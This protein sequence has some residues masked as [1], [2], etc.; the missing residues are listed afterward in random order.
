MAFNLTEYKARHYRENRDEY[1]RRAKA[2]AA[3]HPEQRKAARE[4]W[5]QK[6]PVKQ[7][8][9]IQRY[10]LEN[11]GALRIKSAERR[12]NNPGK[13]RLA[14]KRWREFNRN[15]LQE[16]Q[17]LRRQTDPYYRLVVN[18]RSR[19]GKAMRRRSKSAPTRELLGM[20]IPEFHIYIRGQFRPGMTWEN[21]GSIWHIDH[22]RPCASFDLSD[23]EQQK[24]CFRWD[25]LEPLFVAENLKKGA[26][27]S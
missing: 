6:N 8:E 21:Y 15:R 22:I 24:V 12:K 11:A 16:R 4:K 2:Y 27:L 3:S 25:N 7:K 20:D 23:P 9:S 14:A 5:V 18:L 26:R 1:I 10:C 19:V 17:N 13:Y